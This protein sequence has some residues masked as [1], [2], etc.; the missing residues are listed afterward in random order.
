MPPLQE[1]GDP[2]LRVF[3]IQELVPKAWRGR[4][5][6]TDFQVLNP[7]IT[8]FGHELLMSYRVVTPDSHR[9]LA[10]CRLDPSLQVIPNSLT[11]LSDSIR[12]GGDWHSDPRWLIH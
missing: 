11:L 5:Q 10:T 2:S 4:W 3:A 6:A 1:N 12:D 7:A 8:I 9:R